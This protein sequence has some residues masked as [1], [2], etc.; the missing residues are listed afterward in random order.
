[1]SWPFKMSS[2][3]LWRRPTN[4]NPI[5]QMLLRVA[6][7][8]PTKGAFKLTTLR[9]SAHSSNT[10]TSWAQ[11][12]YHLRS[13]LMLRFLHMPLGISL[14]LLLRAPSPW[15]RN[16]PHRLL[17]LLLILANRTLGSPL[18]MCAKKRRKMAPKARLAVGADRDVVPHWVN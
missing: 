17:L 7:W 9:D 10:T 16:R 18:M 15:T 2:P 4:L 12:N 13:E 1:M 11:I 6:P 5:K 8:P 14:P 3:F